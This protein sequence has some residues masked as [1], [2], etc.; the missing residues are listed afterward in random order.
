MA[1][2][3]HFDLCVVGAGSA[4]YAAAVTARSLGKSVALV[5][6]DGPL[7]GLCI[8]RGCM[9]SKTLLASSDVAHLVGEAPKLGI[10][11][12]DVTID[13][14]KIIERK[15][16][17]IKDFADFRE[18]GI[19]SFPL[20]RGQPEF[21]SERELRVGDERIGAGK[22]IVA[23]GSVI[24]VP[25]IPGLHD[26]GFLTSDDVLELD[27]LPASA[28]VLGGGATA[29]EL[30]QYLARLRVRTMMIQ[31]NAQLMSH[32]DADVA[33]SLQR[34]LEGDGLVILTGCRVERVERRD[35]QRIVSVRDAEGV[36]RTVQADVVF[37]ALGRR[38]SVEGFGLER[39][40][41]AFD[42]G[43]VKI[44]E[45]L[46]TSN[47][48]IFAAGDVTGLVELVHV[49]VYQGQLAARNALC[50]SAD[51][52]DYD[53]QGAR[54]LFTD[55]QVA[56]AGL[57]EREC[58]E[59]GIEYHVAAYPFDDLGKAIS[60]GQT[61]GFIKMLATRDGQLLGVAMVGPEASDMIHEAIALLYFRANVSDVMKMPHLH[62]TLAEIITY[63]A[64]ELCERLAL[65]THAVV[66]P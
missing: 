27:A 12:R 34:Y 2:A 58:R 30:G 38:P 60:I 31:R 11:P 21:V 24:N 15:R 45:Y 3:K 63:P 19:R 53:L 37:A 6:G 50:S 41:V 16:R 66:G 17:I 57:T 25:D 20:F 44:D 23:T 35:G 4:G 64:E 22:F 62:P 55:P 39:A 5:D 10:V 52:A 51:K 29:C 65:E 61:K 32:E 26:S 8:L 43:G 14:P 40:G 54:A 18:V 36:M 7:G 1:D 42:A 33:A 48:D 9:P 49:A 56:I 47:Q 59:R 46:R 28:V 13:Y